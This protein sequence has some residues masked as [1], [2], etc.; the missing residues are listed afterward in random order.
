MEIDLVARGA[1]RAVSPHRRSPG[2]GRPGREES[3]AGHTPARAARCGFGAGL[4]GG[5]GG[6]PRRGAGLAADARPLEGA[7]IPALR[8]NPKSQA[9]RALVRVYRFRDAFRS[10]S[11]QPTATAPAVTE[12][13]VFVA[14]CQPS[15]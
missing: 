8:A 1:G 9:R 10:P 6:P 12:T 7:R 2:A 5:R 13:P 4:Q 15:P 14:F 3:S 11:I